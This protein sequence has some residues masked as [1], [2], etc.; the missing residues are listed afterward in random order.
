MLYS[1]FTQDEKKMEKILFDIQNS[2]SILKSR[3]HG[4]LVFST[5]YQF[6]FYQT[7]LNENEEE[8]LLEFIWG[9]YDCEALA[10]PR[11]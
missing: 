2:N 11:V 5:F 8:E 10:F 9:L 4:L 7:C 1:S 3:Q 6:P